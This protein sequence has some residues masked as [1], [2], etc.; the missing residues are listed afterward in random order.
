ML[1]GARIV[2]TLLCIACFA[3]TGFVYRYSDSRP[4]LP[5][6]DP[7]VVSGKALWQTKNC[8]S[9]HQLYGLGGYMGPDLTNVA[10]KGPAYM[11]AFLKGGTRKMPDFHLTEP[12]MHRLIAFLEWVDQT[13][14]NKIPDSA[15]HWTGS[16]QFKP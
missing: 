11:Q 8:Q 7:E 14:R 12:E 6:P 1:T 15:M 16:Y 5:P 3:Y 13:G 2:L 4:D 10:A 9:C